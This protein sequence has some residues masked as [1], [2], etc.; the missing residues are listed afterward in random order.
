MKSKPA[1]RSVGTIE[2][3]V[4]FTTPISIVG[5][6][7]TRIRAAPEAPRASCGCQLSLHLEWLR[8]SALC[9]LYVSAV[10]QNNRIEIIIPEVNVCDAYHA[11]SCK[12]CLSRRALY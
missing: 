8:V 2:M 6:H 5:T 10:Y 4:L 3:G 9:V 11:A 7:L 1:L 12:R